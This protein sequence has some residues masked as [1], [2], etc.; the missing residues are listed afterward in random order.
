MTE[1]DE[2]R[3][4]LLESADELEC[5]TELSAEHRAELGSDIWA[6]LNSSL[7]SCKVCAARD[8]RMVRLLE[9]FRDVADRIP[10]NDTAR[11]I[12][13]A[14]EVILRELNLE[15]GIEF[16]RILDGERS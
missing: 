1:R 3:A 8:A 13:I 15:I 7:D 11:G 10:K 2:R 12:A 6:E 9:I 14:S 5:G 4:R 16:D